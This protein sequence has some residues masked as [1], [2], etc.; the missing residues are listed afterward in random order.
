MSKWTKPGAQVWSSKETLLCLWNGDQQFNDALSSMPS[1]FEAVNSLND[2]NNDPN[3]DQNHVPPDTKII[4]VGTI[5]PAAGMGY[6]YTA[7]RNRIYGYIDAAFGTDLV[8]KKDELT[9]NQGNSVSIINAIKG[10][11]ATHKIAFLDVMKFAIRVTG[12]SADSDIKCFTLDDGAFCNLPASVLSSAYFI[13]N[14]KNAEFGFDWI[15][16]RNGLKLNK[17][18]LSQRSATKDEWVNGLNDPSILP[19]HF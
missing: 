9:H 8:V 6:Y 10:R 3:N 19:S 1:N 2:P 7:P 14:S 4:I 13:C 16:Q 11:L 12:S 17:K 5:T 15:C 18:C